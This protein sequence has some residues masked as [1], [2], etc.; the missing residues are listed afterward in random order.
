MGVLKLGTVALDGTK[1]HANASRHSALSYQHAGKLEG[2][3]KAEVGVLLAK[4]EAADKADVPDGMSIPEELERREE[5]LKKLAEARTKIEARASERFAREQAEYQAKIA[6]R[7]AKAQASG[8]K[9]GGKPPAPPVAGPGPSDQINLTD[10][11]SRIMPVTGGGFEQCYN[12]QA[13]V[14]AD[15]LLVVAADVVQAANDKQ[16]LEPM[17]SKLAALPK[18]LG[19]PET[20]LGDSGYFS[21]ANVAA[22]AVAGIEPLLAIGHARRQEALRPAQA[23]PRAGVRHHQVGSGLSAILAA[24]ARQGPRRVELGDHGLEHQAD[25]RPQYPVK[26]AGAIAHQP[27]RDGGTRDHVANLFNPSDPGGRNAKRRSIPR[28]AKL[29]SDR[30]LAFPPPHAGEGYGGAALWEGQAKYNV[31]RLRGDA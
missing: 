25:L 6:A 23:H 19:A 29:Q 12:A 1:I 2:Q 10:A 3:L 16:Q 20:L 31:C 13:V 30:L 15:S 11:D 22:C 5:R 14:T 9:P 21:A 17:L 24:R 27:K 28:S 18:V 7:Q 4:A 26:R 8:K